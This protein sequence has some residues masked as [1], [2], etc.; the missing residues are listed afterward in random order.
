MRSEVSDAVR[1]E[2]KTEFEQAAA[3][4]FIFSRTEKLSL[5]ARLNQQQVSRF[6]FFFHRLALTPF[7]SAWRPAHTVTFSQLIFL[8]FAPYTASRLV[9]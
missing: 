3:L 5:C 9:R 1:V 6:L 2:N 4:E 8:T 7:R